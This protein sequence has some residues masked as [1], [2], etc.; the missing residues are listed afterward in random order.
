[1]KKFTIASLLSLLISV[2][3]LAQLAPASAASSGDQEETLIHPQPNPAAWLSGWFIAPTFGTTSFGGTLASSP[4]LRGGIYLNRRVAV[5]L[6]FNGLVTPESSADDQRVRNVG[7][8]GG[9]LLQY[10]VQSN[11]LVHVSFEST[12]GS[13]KWCTEIGD[14]KNGTYDGCQGRTFLV[15]EPVGNVE[16]NV[17]HHVRIATGVGYRFAAAANGD[18]PSSRE[19]SGLVART[20]LVLG[21][22]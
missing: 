22:F 21:T 13:G 15:F 20:S 17:S 14:G 16:F 9:L 11:R 18:G 12:V 6:A 8:Y 19:M 10:V 1:M 7:G 3:A 2:P 5:G 4:G